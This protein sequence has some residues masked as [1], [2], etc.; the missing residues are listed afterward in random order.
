[1]KLPVTANKCLILAILLPLLLGV[2]SCGT[3]F[4]IQRAE[5][6]S[7]YYP[8]REDAKF[9]E[10][11]LKKKPGN[12]TILDFLMFYY[13]W[14]E[15]DK[16]KLREYTLQMVQLHPANSQI[17]GYPISEFYVNPRFRDEVTAALERQI[18]SHTK[19]SGLYWN[20]ARIYQDAAIPPLPKDVSPERKERWFSYFDVPASTPIRTEINYAI[21]AK[22]ESY[23]R[24]AISL[25]KGDKFYYSF[26]AAQLAKL[27]L[28]L[29]RGDEAIAIYEDAIN[30][31]ET[32]YAADDHLSLG[33]I[34][35]KR[36]EY[37]KARLHYQTAIKDDTEENPSKGHVTAR[38]YTGLG[39]MALSQLNIAEAEKD[40]L[41]SANEP[42]PCAHTTTQG[43]PLDLAE[44][45]IA[46]GHSEAPREYLKIVLQKFT[47][48]DQEVKS[49]L[50]RLIGQ[51]M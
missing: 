20:L 43:M 36:Q 11:E 46:Q 39:L 4:E 6:W 38:A 29:D 3:T 41:L 48:E 9:L 17:C 32:R 7:L 51:I 10:A 34:Y 25:V 1:M 30:H 21:A 47:P 40:L 44:A 2:V 49:V 50:D 13:S 37:D 33:A 26:Y 45:L 22:S 5:E 18:P 12:E 16:A 23:F 28:D 42:K 14:H 27:L 24:K 15:R 35:R 8:H 19:K 31:T